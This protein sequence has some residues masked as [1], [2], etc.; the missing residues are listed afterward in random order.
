[1]TMERILLQTIKFDLMTEHPYA[2]VLKY[3]KQLKGRTVANVV[4]LVGFI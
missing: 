4:K 3:A 2:F 1:M